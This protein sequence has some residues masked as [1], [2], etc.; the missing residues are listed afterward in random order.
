M[1]IQDQLYEMPDFPYSIPVVW[2]TIQKIDVGLIVTLNCKN[3]TSSR[4]MFY[5]KKFM[6][7]VRKYERKDLQAEIF[8]QCIK[9]TPGDTI[10]A[11]FFHL[12]PL[13]N[14]NFDKGEKVSNEGD[15]SFRKADI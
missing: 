9:P 3:I 10:T 14:V 2:T 4:M 6:H 1:N 11:A 8:N 7:V 13:V 5:D 12:P 15:L